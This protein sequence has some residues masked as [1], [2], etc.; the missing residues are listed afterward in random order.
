MHGTHLIKSYSKSQQVVALP[1]GEAELYVAVKA[2]SE[3]VRLCS[4]AKDF[5]LNLG[6]RVFADTT[7]ALG[8]ITRRGLGR[9]RHLRAVF[10]GPRSRRPPIDSVCKG[11]G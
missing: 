6:A 5:R 10:V 1:S 3:A 8:I 11:T 4:L 9:I 2:S 7:A